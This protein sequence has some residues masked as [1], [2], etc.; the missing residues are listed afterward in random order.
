MMIEKTKTAK[1][2]LDREFKSAFTNYVDIWC[3]GENYQKEINTLINFD[4]ICDYQFKADFYELN[5]IG[6]KY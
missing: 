1:I 5:Y 6:I 2:N 4:W 3:G